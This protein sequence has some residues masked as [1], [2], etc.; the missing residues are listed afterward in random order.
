ME[1]VIVGAKK[2]G[3]TMTVDVVVT[4]RDASLSERKTGDRPTMLLKIRAA[5]YDLEG[6]QSVDV[7]AGK[8]VTVN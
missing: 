1:G 3:S 5:G 2:D 4:P 7:A 6:P 8:T